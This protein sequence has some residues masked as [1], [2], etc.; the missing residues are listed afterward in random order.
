MSVNINHDSLMPVAGYGS[1]LPSDDIQRPQA[2][3][4][5]QPLLC[6][7][8]DAAERLG[9]SRSSIWRM[10]KLKRIGTVEIMPGT[11]RIRVADIEALVAN[12]GSNEVAHV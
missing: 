10:R 5:H 12:G 6:T 7:M 2:E 9:I 11:Y 4:R 8:S 3:K 1:R